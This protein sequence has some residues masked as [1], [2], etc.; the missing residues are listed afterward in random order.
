MTPVNP[1]GFD[2]NP[3]ITVVSE[4]LRQHRGDLIAMNILGGGAFPLE[5]SK[6]FLDSFENIKYCVIGASSYNHLKENK[7]VFG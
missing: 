4:A 2:M 1:R 3:S 5:E 6:A 7:E